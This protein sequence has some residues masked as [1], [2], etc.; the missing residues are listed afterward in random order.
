VPFGDQGEERMGAGREEFLARLASDFPD[1]MSGFSPYSAGLLHCEVGD[2]RKATERAMDSDRLWE[3]ERH[4]RFVEELLGVA[5][6]ELRNALEVSY[7]EDLALGVCTPARHRAVKERM[8]WALRQILVGH[9]EQ[10][11]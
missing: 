4:F 2:F 6:P 3:A 11:I 8:P 5:D 10:W 9:H 7:L 1:V